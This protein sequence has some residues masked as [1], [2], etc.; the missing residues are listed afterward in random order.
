M[1]ELM[2]Q[3]IVLKAIDYGEK[4][5]IISIFTAEKGRI[6]A[7]LKGVRRATSR[8]KYA[9]QPFCYANFALSR[10]TE[11]LT[12]SDVSEITNYFDITQSYHKMICGSAMLE[13]VEYATATSEPDPVLFEA[14]RRGLGLLSDTDMNPDLVLM[15]FA[16]GLFKVSGYA[17][18]LKNCHIC[19]KPLSQ[20]KV[21]FDLDSGQFCCYKCP[22]PKY[23]PVSPRAVEIIQKIAR[24]PMS[25][26]EDIYIMKEE[27]N[28]FRQIVRANFDLRFGV[29]L[30]SLNQSLSD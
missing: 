15:R 17:L 7:I 18:N 13:M 23:I 30:R 9:T 25:E 28:E 2:T 5:K 21:V 10:R 24:V 3:G 14:L 29:K 22:V 19:G 4:D 16:I 20:D 6:S 1:R 27:A 26:L 12:V 11:L 8:L